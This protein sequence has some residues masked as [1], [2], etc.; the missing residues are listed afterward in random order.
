MRGTQFVSEYKIFVYGKF[1]DTVGS[2]YCMKS[3]DRMLLS[4][5]LEEKWNEAVFI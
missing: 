1:N 2:L 5:E 3:K 4:N